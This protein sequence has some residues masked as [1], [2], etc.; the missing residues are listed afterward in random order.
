MDSAPSRTDQETPRNLPELNHTSAL[1]APTAPQSSWEEPVAAPR[2]TTPAREPMQ[3]ERHEQTVPSHQVPE[4]PR[5]SLELP[6]NSDLV[7]VETSHSA[8][9]AVDE[10]EAPRPRRVR[11]PR[12]Q[13]PDEPLQMVET[14]RKDTDTPAE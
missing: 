6:P 4:L 2:E 1:E 13:T 5:V 12:A 3:R 14:T 9:P 11:P 7:L 8:P 10:A